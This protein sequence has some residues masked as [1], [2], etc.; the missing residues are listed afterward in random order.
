MTVTDTPSGGEQV[1]TGRARDAAASRRALF[2]AAQELFG[3]KGYERTT[4]REIG[5]RAG[6]DAALIARYYGGKADLYIAVVTAEPVD[7]RGVTDGA[8]GADGAEEPY[9]GLA[10]IAETL[11]DRTDRHG[12][13]PIM[14]ALIR[15][16]TSDEIREAARGRLIRRIVDPLV[17]SGEAD[18]V[19]RPRLRAEVAVAALVGVSLGRALGWFDELQS[20][21]RDELVEL[22]TGAL[23]LVIDGTVGNST[24]D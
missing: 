6:V 23:A 15:L 19:D 5:E 18:G 11:F 2:L 12:P 9:E 14:Q 1:R 10:L 13:G 22:V 8:D 17:A 4:I 24:G 21:P 20:V 7:E 3:Q 16:D